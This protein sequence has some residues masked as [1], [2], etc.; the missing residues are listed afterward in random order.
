[1]DEF[2]KQ[3]LAFMTEAKEKQKE[4]E[5]RRKM[6]EARSKEERKQVAERL[7][8]LAE[9]I[10]EIVKVGTK[11]EIE[12]A[13]EPIRE[14]QDKMEKDTEASNAKINK[15][16]EDMNEMKKEMTKMNENKSDSWSAKVKEGGKKSLNEGGMAKNHSNQCPRI[17][18][19]EI[20]D[21]EAKVK[22]II[23]EAKKI[24]G[25]KPIDKVHVQHT[26]RRNEEDDKDKDNEERWEKAMT[27]TVESFLKYEMKMTQDDMSQLK[28]VKIFPPA[29]DNWDI[30]Y[31]EFESKEMVN[32]LMSFTKFMRRDVKE[33]RPSILKY[34]PKELFT[35]Y[36]AVEAAAFEIR[37]Q[38]NFKEATNVSFGEADLVLKT[39]SKDIH[40]GGTKKPWSQVD[41]V[42]LPEDLPKFDLYPAKIDPRNLRSP[43]QAPG[44]PPLTPEQSDK[45]KD[46][47][48]PCSQAS[49][50]SSLQKK[51]K[52]HPSGSP[53]MILPAF[54]NKQISKDIEMQS[55]VFYRSRGSKSTTA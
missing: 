8:G 32:F 49:P 17:A 52:I 18:S 26:M 55:P 51:M 48:T 4:D 44:R 9:K 53:T 46:R 45:R 36:S 15:L 27:E 38:S 23:R 6:E 42:V 2:Q 47:G 11:K 29:K 43:T 37:K 25:M 12:S 19:P 41:P 35:R 39:R 50:D 54:N 1:M 30:L 10:A 34:I 3:M 22:K 33:N 16:V 40:P 13:V 14:R 31:V 21:K 24:V 5:E 20:E 28:I 7:N